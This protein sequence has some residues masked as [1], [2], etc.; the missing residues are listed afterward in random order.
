[1][2]TEQD[3]GT[4]L[5]FCLF[6]AAK[7]KIL[8]CKKGSRCLDYLLAALEQPAAEAMLPTCTFFITTLCVS[9]PAYIFTCTHH[10]VNNFRVFIL[11]ADRKFVFMYC[12]V[13]LLSDLVSL[14]MYCLVH[15]ISGL[16]LIFG[17]QKTGRVDSWL[18]SEVMRPVS[19]TCS[20]Y[21]SMIFV[22]SKS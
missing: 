14:C 3:W 18:Q 10:R 19:C 9:L 12:L 1:M 20:F 15:Q 13:H 7:R 8:N 16:I 5:K 21:M 4:V 17:E 2:A 6:F 11:Q 22:L